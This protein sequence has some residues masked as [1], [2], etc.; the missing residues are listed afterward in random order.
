MF[1]ASGNADEAIDEKTLGTF[2][3]TG[4]PLHIITDF[5]DSLDFREL[6]DDLK[7]RYG[8]D[9]LEETLENVREKVEQ[10][11][12]ARVDKGNEGFRLRLAKLAECP[13]TQVNNRIEIRKEV[14][15]R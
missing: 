9:S 12:N 14:L 15:E 4:N 5:F 11:K 7:E 6:F 3:I 8:T 2:F 1:N 13:T 10:N